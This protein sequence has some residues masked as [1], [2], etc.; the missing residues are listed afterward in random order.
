[1]SGTLTLTAA[2]TPTSVRMS[3]VRAKTAI[4]Y[5]DVQDINGLPYNLTG[6]VMYFH[7]SN[8]SF[9]IDKSTLIGGSPA[10]VQGIVY[11]NPLLGLATLTIDPADT[12]SLGSAGV[13]GMPCEFTLT[14]GSPAG[15]LELATGNL[16]ISPN[17]G[18]P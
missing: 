6:S 11:S 9:T 18:T 8:G 13:F 4:Y 17:V 3:I 15:T 16:T 2:V 12:S 14:G 10:V 1:M 7:A 5:I